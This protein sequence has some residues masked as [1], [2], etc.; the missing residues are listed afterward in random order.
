MWGIMRLSGDDAPRKICY[1]CEKI[2]N[3]QKDS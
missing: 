3:A 2:E 1:E